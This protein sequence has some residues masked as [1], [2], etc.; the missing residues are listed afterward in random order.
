[1]GDAMYLKHKSSGDLVEVLNLEALFDPC[2]SIIQGR[3]H[4]EEELQDPAPF[5][6][7]ELLFPS[8]ENLP[9]CWLDVH[10]REKAA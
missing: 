10:Y 4:A 9:H 2:R 3:L 8:G 5:T 1:M 7:A 6:K